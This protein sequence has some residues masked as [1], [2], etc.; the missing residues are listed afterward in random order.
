MGSVSRASEEEH[1]NAL[2]ATKSITF[3]NLHISYK[4]SHDL[5]EQVE[6]K[7]ILRIVPL[8]YS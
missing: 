4:V 5:K 3:N 6:N 7:L 1:L 8:S 2:K